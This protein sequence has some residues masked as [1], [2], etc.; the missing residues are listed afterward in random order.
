MSYQNETIK[1][2]LDKIGKNALYLPAIQRKFVWEYTQIENLF[3]SLMRK[4]PIGT[5]LFW[6]FKTKK[7]NE[8][9]F[10]KFLQEYH[11]RDKCINDIAPRPHLKKGIL[12][13][14]DGQQR[15]SSLYIALQGSYAYKKPYAR[16]EDDSAYPKRK[17]YLNIFKSHEEKDEDGFVWEFK[18]LTDEESKQNDNEHHQY[19]QRAINRYGQ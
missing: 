2:M 13:V 4:Y 9:V 18:F 3:D 8:Y 12:G 10:Y 1:N 16:R 11:E 17:L 6:S 19:R 15:L 14:L 5:F 7:K